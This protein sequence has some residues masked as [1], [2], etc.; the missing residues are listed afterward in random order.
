MKEKE[1]IQKRREA[2]EAWDRAIGALIE[3]RNLEDRLGVSQKGVPLG[4][5]RVIRSEEDFEQYKE[6]VTRENGTR[7]DVRH[8]PLSAMESIYYPTLICTMSPGLPSFLH[9]FLDPDVLINPM[10][11]HRQLP[12]EPE[13]LPEISCSTCGAGYSPESTTC[14]QCEGT[15]KERVSRPTDEGYCFRCQGTGDHIP[16]QPIPGFSQCPRCGG[17]GQEPDTCQACGGAGTLP[18]GND[19]GTPRPCP[20]CRDRSNWPQ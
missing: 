4:F 12:Q 8:T 16:L 18:D 6:G 17:S 1:L 10:N 11:A 3:L 20:G 9:F 13:D 14:P 19:W 7:Y 5:F 15:G 2:R